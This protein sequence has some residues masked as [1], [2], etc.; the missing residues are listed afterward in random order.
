MNVW[1]SQIN[2]SSGSFSDNIENYSSN[3]TYFGSIGLLDLLVG[4]FKPIDAKM[5]VHS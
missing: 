2:Y 5:C 4:T 3:I 1:L